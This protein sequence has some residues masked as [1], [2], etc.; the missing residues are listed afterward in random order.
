[1]QNKL[2]VRAFFPLF[3]LKQNIN[4]Q[5]QGLVNI[6]AQ[7]ENHVRTSGLAKTFLFIT[8]LSIF[9]FRYYRYFLSPSCLNTTASQQLFINW[10]C[11]YLQCNF[12]V[13]EIL[14]RDFDFRLYS[15]D[16]DDLAEWVKKWQW[17]PK[18]GGQPRHNSSPRRSE[19]L[20]EFH[21]VATIWVTC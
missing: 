20:H 8:I 16:F 12:H 4:R 21:T 3:P 14:K 18:S 15:W 5:E 2:R 11:T 10:A 9:F 6:Y 7:E 19:A 1:M 17:G 13:K